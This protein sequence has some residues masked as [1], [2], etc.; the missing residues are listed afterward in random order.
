MIATMLLSVFATFNLPSVH[1]PNQNFNHLVVIA[2][3]NEPYDAIIGTGSGT[4][5]DH[6]ISSLIPHST[7]LDLNSY[8]WPTYTSG[9]SAECYT[10]FTSGNGYNEQDCGG[11][12]PCSGGYVSQNNIFN[13]SLAPT[14]WQGYCENNCGRQQDHFPC[15]QYANTY[16]NS[17]CATLS[18]AFVNGG[19]LNSQVLNTFNSATPPKYIFL[20]PDDTNNMH[21]SS[22]STGDSWLQSFLVGSG[23]ITSPASGSLL[24]T[25]LFT[26]ASDKTLLIVWWDESLSGCSPCGPFSNNDKAEIYYG[27]NAN[28]IPNNVITS[29]QYNDFQTL[30]TIENNL[31]LA[32]LSQDCSSTDISSSIFNGTPDFRISASPQSVTTQTGVAGSSTISVTSLSGFTGT[33]TL[34][35]TTSSP[36]LVCS[37]SPTSI[38]GGSGTSTL[39]CSSN[40]A[41]SYIAT[42]TGTSGTLTHS[43]DVTV[44]VTSPGNFDTTNWYIDNCAGAGTGTETIVNGVLQLRE[45]SPGGNDNNYAYCTTQRGS[46]PW[47]GSPAGTAL[48]ADLTLVSSPVGFLTSTSVTSS[49]RYHLLI[50]LYYQ[51]PSLPPSNCPSGGLGTDGKCWLDTQSRV[52]HYGGNDIA[53]GTTETYTSQALGWANVTAI[54]DPGQT[55][56]LTA[57]VNHQCQADLAAW[58]LPT[59]TTCTLKGVEIGTEGFQFAELDTNWN[60]YTFTT[61]SQDFTITAS[62][63][64]VT[65]N[66]NN[67]GTSTIT[68]AP[69]NG[70]GGTVSL[71]VT[72]NSTNLSCTVSPTSITG[73]SGTSTLSCSSGTAGNY[74]ATVTGTSGTLAHST[75]V[76]FAVSSSCPSPCVSPSSLVATPSLNIQPFVYPWDGSGFYA[77]GRDWVFYLST[78]SCSG[79]TT[80]CLYYATSTNGASWTSYNVGV[81]SGATPSVVTN[82]THVFY[83]R[84]N[85]IDTSAGQALMFRVGALHPDGTI[86]W[87]AETTVKPATSGVVWYSL[88]LGVSTTGQVF[89][90]YRNSTSGV[91]PDGGSALP[92]VIH[93]NGQDY[94]TWQQETLLT[95][96]RDNWRFSLVPLPSGQ[97]YILYWPYWGGLSGRI[98]SSG[99]WGSQVAVT[100]SGT[101]V[102]QY[103]FGFSTGNSTVYAI[104]Q[105]RTSQKLQ[106]VSRT[107]SWGTPQTIGIAD[108]GTNTRWTAS[109]DSLQGKWY[110]VYYN[111]T[112]NQ[113]YQY[114]GVPGSWSGKTQLYTTQATSSTVYIGSFPKT[115]QVTA[116]KYVL[117]IFWTQNPVAGLQLMFGNETI[118]PG[119][120]AILAR[121]QGE[122]DGALLAS[123]YGLVAAIAI[124][125][126]I[127]AGT[128]G[129]FVSA[130]LTRPRTRRVSDQ[131]L[132]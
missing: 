61:A 54:I 94:S 113:I 128:V 123:T 106:F 130:T 46:F 44:A 93:S 107:T 124:L 132:E 60:G 24:S 90:A 115:G 79:T 116:S 114:S 86:A 29:T 51:L 58:S 89:V 104:Y 7:V 19:V 119:Q 73:G 83:V 9:C 100:P 25:S 80:N 37:L 4:P 33:V 126:L 127:V 41:A 52:E 16:Q 34:A 59:S 105:E 5:N 85:G 131:R 12:V 84:Y 82:G 21:S 6:F 28:V 102:Q 56:T 101:Y 98:W 70:F 108:T 65:V 1:A 112:T 18:G 87:Q 48:P 88:S 35:V 118:L 103:A 2:M 47:G 75:T 129:R 92:F 23:S 20:T 62:P 55:G 27:P 32:C 45:Q 15:L 17:Q 3:E 13:P 97:M 22:V 42:V 74:L 78:G 96:S 10:A 30:R 110:V 63:T 66:V 121:P 11:T 69:V 125:S 72:T 81:V 122:S 111:Y 91:T 39:S 57:D 53:V 117:G 109:Y 49:S 76:T 8:G 50:A 67:A 68:I 120:T 95:T 14:G 38:S 71:G 36:N 99:T 77:Q 31:G 40:I 64:G 43:T 26:T